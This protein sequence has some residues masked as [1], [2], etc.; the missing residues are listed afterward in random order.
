MGPPS[1]GVGRV[2]MREKLP[3]EF[4]VGIRTI[5]IRQMARP[6]N[7]RELGIRQ[8]CSELPGGALAAGQVVL[9]AQHECRDRQRVQAQA[10][11]GFGSRGG[12]SEI[13]AR[14]AG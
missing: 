14:I 9:A 5:E 7:L 4:A 8:S 11:G 13:V 2:V 6:G 1:E 3:A 12:M 10:R